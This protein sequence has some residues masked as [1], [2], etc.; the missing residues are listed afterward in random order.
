M[1][2]AMMKVGRMVR[3]KLWLMMCRRISQGGEDVELTNVLHH[4]ERTQEEGINRNEEFEVNSVGENV[5]SGTLQD[6][7]MPKN[8]LEE[9]E[10]NVS[11]TA[12]TSLE[13][14]SLED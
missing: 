4:I 2:L 10:Q 1:T 3:E 13:V 8:C 11:D 9:H 5:R 12:R 14:L 7:Q 6:A